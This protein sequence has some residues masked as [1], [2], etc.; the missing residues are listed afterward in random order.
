[1][2]R[3]KLLK[4][5]AVFFCAMLL[6]TFLSR[7]A[8]SVSVARVQASTIQNQMITHQVSGSGTIEGT[9]EEAVF[10]L[11]NQKVAQVLVQAGET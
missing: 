3:E 8:D 5:I 7:A 1:M 11:E 4:W 2:R 10:T 6:F 9:Q